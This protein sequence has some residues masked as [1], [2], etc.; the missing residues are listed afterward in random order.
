MHYYKNNIFANLVCFIYIGFNVYTM[1]YLYKNWNKKQTNFDNN[2]K[3][4]L[5][6]K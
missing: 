1:D 4:W 6:K 5:F 3:P 2:I